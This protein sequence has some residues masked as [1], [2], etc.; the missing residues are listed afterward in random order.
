MGTRHLLFSDSVRLAHLRAKAPV[1]YKTD[2]PGPF[3]IMNFDVQGFP[4]LH[5]SGYNCRLPMQIKV[6]RHPRHVDIKLQT[7]KCITNTKLPDGH[8][9]QKPGFVYFVPFRCTTSP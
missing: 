5:I 6:C 9:Q 4:I 3:P 1:K 2:N 8:P 7:R